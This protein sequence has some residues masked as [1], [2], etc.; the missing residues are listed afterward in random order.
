MKVGKIQSF[1]ANISY[2]V[3]ELA[4]D[5][6]KKG[7]SRKYVQSVVRKVNQLF[8]GKDYFIGYD[9]YNGWIDK[10]LK[11]TQRD[12]VCTV[13]TVEKKNPKDWDPTKSIYKQVIWP[14]FAEERKGPVVNNE[15]MAF[16]NA[17][18]T[19]AKKDFYH[20]KKLPGW[21]NAESIW[22]V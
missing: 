7:M 16:Y 19:L 15:L 10:D 13:V 22:L 5:S 17:I 20:E 21:N 3:G 2:E 1:R 9:G 14:R 4:S 12:I 18:K 8:P 11:K 6:V